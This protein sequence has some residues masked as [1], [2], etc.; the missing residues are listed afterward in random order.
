LCEYRGSS[1]VLKEVFASWQ[2]ALQIP[3]VGRDDKERVVTD[4]E[5]RESD[6]AEPLPIRFADFKVRNLSPLVI[7]NEVET[8]CESSP[9]LQ[10]SFASG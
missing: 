3:P 5:F 7:P 4:L 8:L 9:V 1:R 2:G 10:G 6:G